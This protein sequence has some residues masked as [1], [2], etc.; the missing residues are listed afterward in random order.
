MVRWEVTVCHRWHVRQA[1]PPGRRPCSASSA[2]PPS[3]SPSPAS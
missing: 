2:V 3:T 1:D